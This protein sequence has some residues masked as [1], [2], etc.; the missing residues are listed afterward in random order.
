MPTVV[1]VRF[2]YNPKSYWFDIAGSDP[3]KNDLLVVERSN[4]KIFG[5]AE[6]EPFEISEEQEEELKSPLKPILRIATEADLEIKAQLDEMGQAAKSTFREL[7]QKHELDIKPI[8]VEYLMDSDSAI[9]HFSSEERVDFRDLVKDLAATLKIHVDMKQIGVRDEARVI[10]G[11]GHCGK[12]LCCVSTGG[13]FQPVSIRMAKEQDLPLNPSKVSGACGRLMCCL[14]YEFEAYKDFK[15][16]APKVGA[17]IQTPVG[18]ATVVEL[19][20]LK[21]QIKLKLEDSEET[22]T[23]PLSGMITD[24]S[25]LEAKPNIVT[26]ETFE[27]NMPL[28]M[29]R[30]KVFAIPAEEILETDKP[31]QKEEK[32]RRRQNRKN[33]QSEKDL[34]KRSKIETQS[35]QENKASKRDNAKSRVQD[36]SDTSGAV[37]QSRANV[38]TADAEHKRSR[39]TRR[40]KLNKSKSTQNQDQ[41]RQKDTAR[42]RKATRPRPGQNSSSIRNPRDKSVSRRAR[43]S[44]NQSK[45]SSSSSVSLPK[46]NQNKSRNSQQRRQDNNST[47]DG[48]RKKSRGRSP[49]R[50]FDADRNRADRQDSQRPTDNR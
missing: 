8:S 39:S 17:A 48:I 33:Q 29:Q 21:E 12:E 47:G 2:K 45:E 19:L 15:S 28:S 34:E 1:P 18:Q 20:T 36:I 43:K 30:E 27:Q 46:Q 32:R 6:D 35:S 42:E 5:W 40:Q 16:R 23:V 22:F 26:E 25:D 3:H 49:R 31:K 37:V 11:L 24:S 38:G 10:G 13:A 4:A 50:T 9:F 44:Q 7:V 14:R 41:N